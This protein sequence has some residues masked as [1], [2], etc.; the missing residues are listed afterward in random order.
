MPPRHRTALFCG[1]WPRGSC[2]PC[3]LSSLSLTHAHRIDQLPPPLVSCCC[4]RE[5][6]HTAALNL[7]VLI[8]V[9]R[10]AWNGKAAY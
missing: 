4:A 9:K 6:A 2:C 7:S 10:A 3:R 8:W 1:V 5:Q